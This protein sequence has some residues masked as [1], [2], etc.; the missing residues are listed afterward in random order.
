MCLLSNQVLQPTHVQATQQLD[1]H[2][3]H[4]RTNQ[5]ECNAASRLLVVPQY[6]QQAGSNQKEK[7]E[8]S[9]AR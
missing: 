1:M 5:H 2:R 9:G 4:N 3:V 8:I 6:M 7:I